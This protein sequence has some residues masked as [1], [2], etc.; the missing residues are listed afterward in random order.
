[1][2]MEILLVRYTGKNTWTI[3]Q[4]VPPDKQWKKLK[5]PQNWMQDMEQAVKIAHF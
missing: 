4:S 3:L 2:E 1:M 5:F